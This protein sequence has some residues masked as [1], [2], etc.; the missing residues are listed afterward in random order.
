MAAFDSSGFDQAAFDPTAFDFGEGG[1]DGEPAFIGPDIEDQVLT[2]DVAM[3]DV[4]FS[5]LFT[6]DLPLTFAVVGVLPTGLALSGAGVLSGTPTVV[7]ATAGLIIRASDGSNPDADSNAFSIT[8]AAAIVSAGGRKRD[9]RR[10]GFIS[11][12]M[13]RG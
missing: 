5:T 12:L 8:I 2:V 3:V 10:R 11:S 13:G 7:G 9:G 1:G 4:D 6:A